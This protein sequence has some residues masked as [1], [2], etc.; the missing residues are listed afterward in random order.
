MV[1]L[2]EAQ[3]E[4]ILHKH[5]KHQL[6]ITIW[7]PPQLILLPRPTQDANLESSLGRPILKKVKKLQD[8]LFIIK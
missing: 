5:K 8:Q 3:F 2:L 7:Q 4:R 6:L 1:L